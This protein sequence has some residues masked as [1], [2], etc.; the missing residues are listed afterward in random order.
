MEMAADRSDFGRRKKV[1]G[2]KA[3]SMPVLVESFE[4]E[5]LQDTSSSM[6]LFGFQ[7]Q[8]SV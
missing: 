1:R 8:R 4:R 2:L 7:E 5:R 6:P 3:H